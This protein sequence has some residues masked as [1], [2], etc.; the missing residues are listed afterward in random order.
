VPKPQMLRLLLGRRS[1]GCPVIISV[2]A[3]ACPARGGGGAL[4]TL[5][6]GLASEKGL[7]SSAVYLQHNTP[8]KSNSQQGRVLKPSEEQPCIQGCAKEHLLT[9]EMVKGISQWQ[10]GLRDKGRLWVRSLTPG[11]FCSSPLQDMLPMPGD[12]TQGTGNYNIEDFADLGM[13]PPFSE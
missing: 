11:T 13:F 4:S 9:R 3:S 2:V 12:P 1:Y 10:A 7:Y 5:G 6:P 8:Q